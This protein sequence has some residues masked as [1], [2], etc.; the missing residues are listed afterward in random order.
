M[1]QALAQYRTM[2]STAMQDKSK[3]GGGREK[4][5]SDRQGLRAQVTKAS[6]E[7]TECSVSPL[8]SGT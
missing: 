5:I 6:Q 8:A 3:E 2:P 1:K 7:G 4:K